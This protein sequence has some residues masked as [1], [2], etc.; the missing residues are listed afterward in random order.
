MRTTELVQRLQ[1]ERQPLQLEA[2]ISKLDRFH[3]LTLDDILHVTKDG[4]ETT[5]LFELIADRYGHHPLPTM[6]NQPFLEW[7]KVFL[8][9]A[10][11]MAAIDR[12]V[13]HATI[14]EMN[15]ENSRRRTAVGRKTRPERQPSEQPA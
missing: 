10:V 8:D 12:G 1:T 9:P 3:L 15:V 4:V 7:S 14:F 6:A 2:A 5:A 11:T 13:H